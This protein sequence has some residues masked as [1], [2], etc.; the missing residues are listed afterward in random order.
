MDSKERLSIVLP[1]HNEA[2]NLEELLNRLQEV[3]RGLGNPYEIIFVD[4]GSTDGSFEVLRKLHASHPYLKVIRFKKNCGET[5]ALDA[6][7]KR[8]QGQVVVAMDSDLQSDPKDIPAL[9]EKLKDHDVA[10]GIRAERKD[11]LARRMVSWGGNI[12][13]SKLM[14]DSPT[15]A[16]SPLRA[17]RKEVVEKI[18][19]FKGL[20]RFYP[21]LCRIEG[22][23]VAE[24]PIAHYPRKSGQ[25]K[26]NIRN[27]LFKFIID[28]LAVKW[29]QSRRLDYEVLEELDEKTP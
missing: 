8:A 27:R 28:L 24:V 12:L 26:Y 15:D 6:G 11:T 23:R 22:F 2:G 10:W 5:A 3:L 9:L 14:G 21:T 1:V 16:G 7:F 25:S 19:L 4:D 17:M 29:M 13:R 18:R 20:H